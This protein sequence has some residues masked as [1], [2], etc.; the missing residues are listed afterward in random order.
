MLFRSASTQVI[1]KA[2]T[3]LSKDG[4]V[5]DDIVSNSSGAFHLI[6]ESV[7]RREVV[8]VFA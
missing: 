1:A 5:V 3:S 7:F 2:Y 6:E 8:E 4:D